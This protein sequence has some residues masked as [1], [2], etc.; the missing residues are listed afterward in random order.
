MK[1]VTHDTVPLS[2]FVQGSFATPQ[3]P[4]L[5]KYGKKDSY[6]KVTGLKCFKWEAE[7]LGNVYVRGFRVKRGDIGDLTVEDWRHNK[8]ICDATMIEKGFGHLFLF[9]Y[10]GNG[11]TTVISP[12]QI[13]DQAWWG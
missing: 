9:N 1:T 6:Y 7:D 2:P 12:E 5:M 13:Y 11:E 8:M 4:Y 3:I 10:L